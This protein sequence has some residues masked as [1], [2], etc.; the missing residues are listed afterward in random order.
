MSKTTPPTQPWTKDAI[1]LMDIAIIFSK[2]KWQFFSLLAAGLVLTAVFLV[3]RG[4]V[5]GYQ[6]ILVGPTYQSA[7]QTIPSSVFSQAALLSA[8]HAQFISGELVQ[9]F[10]PKIQFEQH[11]VRYQIIDSKTQA[12]TKRTLPNHVALSV[13]GRGLSPQKAADFLKAA[14]GRLQKATRDYVSAWRLNRQH[15]LSYLTKQL[16]INA[17][18]QKLQKTQVTLLA[19][20]TKNMNSVLAAL[21]QSNLS[22]TSLNRVASSKAKVSENFVGLA[23]NKTGALANQNALL[24]SLYLHKQDDALS[25]VKSR[26]DLTKNIQGFQA[27]LDSLKPLGVVGSVTIIPGSIKSLVKLGFLGLVVSLMLAFVLVLVF[28]FCANVKRL[29]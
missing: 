3:V 10:S 1:S 17:Q 15:N 24:V 6:Q 5:R 2:R 9:E 20:Q 13:S 28:E 29:T 18:E 27:M 12:I 21:P 26:I 14:V 16:N 19:R 7:G 23:L 22:P 11:E 25:T 4:P 8:V